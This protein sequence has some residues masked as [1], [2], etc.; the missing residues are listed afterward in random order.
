L[1]KI[2]LIGSFCL[3]GNFAFATQ[4]QITSSNPTSIKKTSPSAPVSKPAIITQESSKPK[5]TNVITNLQNKTSII[6]IE[7]SGVGVTPCEGACSVAQARVM[8]RRAAIVDAYKSLAEKMY[9]IK[10][11][12]RDTVKNMIL[13]NSNLRSYVS[14][15]IRGANIVEEDFKNGIY[16]IVLSLKLDVNEWNKFIKNNPFAYNNN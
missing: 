9:G 5:T 13:Q 2:V 11:N 8:A 14:G 7:A 3:I 10:I 6:T 1:K 15:L 12:G 4:Q 16:S